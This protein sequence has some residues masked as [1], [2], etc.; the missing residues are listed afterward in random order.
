MR[1]VMK[2]LL[3]RWRKIERCAVDDPAWDEG[4]AKMAGARIADL[5]VAVV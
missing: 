4:L 3:D 5:S 1:T 2:D